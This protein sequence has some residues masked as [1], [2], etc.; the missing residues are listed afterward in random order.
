MLAS[1][2]SVLT[3]AQ[4]QMTSCE[5][6]MEDAK[7]DLKNKEEKYKVID[8]DLDSDE[9]KD[10][11]KKGKGTGN[12]RKRRTENAENQNNAQRR[13]GR[14]RRVYGTTNNN[15]DGATSTTQ[16]TSN[17]V[18]RSSTMQIF[19]KPHQTTYTLNVKP[20]DTIADVKAKICA[21]NSVPP[22]LQGLRY[23]GKNLVDEK[24]LSFY[25]VSL[26]LDYI[27]YDY[28][29]EFYC[30]AQCSLT[31]KQIFFL[32]SLYCKIQNH[33]TLQFY[34]RLDIQM[35][36][37]VKTLTG[38]PVTIDV[39]PSTTVL[40]VK[41][42]MMV[43]EGILPA[44]QRLLY[45]GSVLEDGKTLSACNIQ[46]Q[47]TLMLVVSN[48]DAIPINI[49]MPSGKS[50]TLNVQISDKVSVLQDKIRAVEGIAPS[51]QNLFFN[52]RALN[53]DDLLSDYGIQRESK[54]YL[55]RDRTSPT[56]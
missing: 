29:V 15:S 18:T 7:E 14:Q 27:L 21:K 41:Q 10:N 24:T 25:N 45:G 9:E 50:I 3:S 4:T 23:G 56:I 2:K 54:L 40:E 47:S 16:S 39:T 51:Q 6:E 17:M 52:G 44:R 49:A 1:A 38:N 36:I 19:V 11:A 8:V 55:V 22:N 13:D 31:S 20:S 5:K 28:D 42:K 12:S 35:K 43:K 48:R 30:L 33:S 32:L 34:L 46:S 26:L 53:D 37:Y